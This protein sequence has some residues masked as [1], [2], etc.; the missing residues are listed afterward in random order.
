MVDQTHKLNTAKERIVI[1]EKLNIQNKVS[2]RW[3]SILE[4][5]TWYQTQIPLSKK[6][7]ES[8]NP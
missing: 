2:S 8:R 1:K 4:N 5:F 7:N 6:A 3:I